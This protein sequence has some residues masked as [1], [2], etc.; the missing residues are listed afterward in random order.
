MLALILTEYFNNLHERENS[1]SMLKSIVAE[2][3]H[4]KISLKE[5]NSYNLQV[6]D[7]IDSALV[8]WKIRLV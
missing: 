8:N 2:L 6:L 1:N 3:N 5:M 7:K 4:N